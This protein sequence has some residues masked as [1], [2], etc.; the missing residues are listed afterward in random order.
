MDSR[1]GQR[2]ARTARAPSRRVGA[3]DFGAGPST[4]HGRADG[5]LAVARLLLVL[6]NWEHLVHACAEL[7][8]RVLQPS[9]RLRVRATSRDPLGVAGETTWRVPPL[10]LPDRRPDLPAAMVAQS[11]AA[12][13]FAQRASEALPGLS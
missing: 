7:A 6:D 8:L 10:G 9:P 13:L 4:A 11:E 5:W 12:R 3:W 2:G 1:P